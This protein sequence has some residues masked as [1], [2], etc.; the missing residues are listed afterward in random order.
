MSFVAKYPDRHFL[1]EPMV[2]LAREE[3]EHFMQVYRLIRKRNEPY[4]ASDSRDPYVGA[5]MDQLR[6]GRDE[7]FLDRLV[8]SALIE[9]RGGERFSLLAQQLCK[10][11]DKSFYTD[12]ALRERGHY[13]IFINIAAKYFGASELESAVE[14][15]S[16]LESEV[17][18]AMPLTH[19]LH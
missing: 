6:H 4:L 12:L 11:E 14:R 10:P 9:A 3:M 8:L 15:L 17:M 13:K 5:M 1:I 19:R 16:E 7:R 18:L 2:S